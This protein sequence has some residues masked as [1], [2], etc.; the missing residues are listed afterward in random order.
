MVNNLGKRKR[1]LKSPNFINY[2]NITLMAATYQ[3]I[4]KTFQL[5]PYIYT[6]VDTKTNWRCLLKIGKCYLKI[7]KAKKKKKIHKENYLMSY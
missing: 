6:T 2:N 3:S 1:L 5:Y 7:H 4:K